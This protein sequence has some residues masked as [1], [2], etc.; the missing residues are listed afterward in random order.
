MS[1]FV[2][3]LPKN[4]REIYK[5]RLADYKGHKFIDMRRGGS[6]VSVKSGKNKVAC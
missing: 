5:F 1:K 6:I 4:S 3:E 2:Y